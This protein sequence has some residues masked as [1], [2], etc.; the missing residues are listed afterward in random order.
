MGL[1]MACILL[2]T[3]SA[4]A[5]TG[6]TKGAVRNPLDFPGPSIVEQIQAAIHDCAS[7][8]APCEISIPAGTYTASPVSTWRNRF[9]ADVNVGVAIPSNVEIHGAGRSLTVIQVKRSTTDPLA[10]LFSNA[11]RSNRNI[12]LRDLSVNWSDFGPKWNWVSIFLCHGCEQLELDHLY[13]E[14]NANKLV[15]LLDSTRSNVHDNIFALHPTGYGH[16]DNALSFNRFDSTLAVRDAAGEVHDNQFIQS[17][18]YRIFSMLVVTQSQLLIQGNTFE[19][20]LPP[21][22]NATAI[23]CGQDNT[24]HLPEHVKISGNMFY[25]ASIIGALNNYEISNNFLEHGDIYAALQGGMSNSLSGGTIADNELHFGSIAVGATEH[26]FTGRILITRNRVFDGNIGTGNPALVHDI[27]VSYNSVRYSNNK[28]GIDCNACS[29][30]RGNVVRETG[31]NVPGD[32]SAGYLVS[33]TVQDVSDNVYLDEQHAYNTGTVCSVANPVSK[34]CLALLDGRL[35]N[36]ASSRWVLLS[37]GEWG[38]GWSNRILSLD[39]DHRSLPIRAFHS[40]SLLELDEDAPL[41]QPRT[42]YHLFRTTYN[43]FE[44]N[45]AVIERFANNLVVSPGG[46]RHAAVQENGTVRIRNLSGNVFHPY[47][48]TGKCALDYRSNVSPPD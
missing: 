18:T 20:H 28:S 5:L 2:R 1:F 31:Q 48:C 35:E 11:D 14:G 17:G 42:H 45:S 12:R 43:A 8:D 7:A 13:L 26:T 22:G 29:L 33:G 19:A 23:E 21:P 32:I 47:S 4:S 38:F 15:N 37:G 10:A 24:L 40:S 36:H 6:A 3:I 34:I 41:L 39:S 25:G 27:E 16:G 44:L 30:I 9:G 46:F